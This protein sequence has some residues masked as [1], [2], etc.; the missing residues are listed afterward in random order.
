MHS[1]F[2]EHLEAV[3]GILRYLKTNPGR[4]LSFKKTSQKKVFIHTNADWALGRVS[5]IQKI[6]L[7]ISYIC[8]G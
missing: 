2:E 1:P 3:Y 7:R 5:H 6:N 8:L 4:G